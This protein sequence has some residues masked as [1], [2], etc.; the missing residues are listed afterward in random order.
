MKRNKTNIHL[1]IVFLIFLTLSS[2]ITRKEVTY[3]QGE[4]KDNYEYNF[5][6]YKLRPNDR[7]YIRLFS[8]NEEINKLLN[9]G[10][11]ANIGGAGQSQNMFVFIISDYGYVDIPQLDSVYVMNKT[12]AE[13]KI[14]VQRVLNSLYK[15]SKADVRLADFTYTILG[16]VNN[17]GMITFNENRISIIEAVAAAGDFSTF[18]DRTKVKIVRQTPEGSKIYEVDIT[19]SD[20]LSSDF[21]YLHP[22]DFVYVEPLNVAF[23]NSKYYPLLSFTSVILSTTSAVLVF[24]SLINRNNGQ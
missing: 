4:Q 8:Q 19:Q 16:E 11:Q 9:F 14:E 15:N 23:V 22:N 10:G 20:I 18:A 7:L 17:P 24:I 2:C 13:A 1:Y 12:I 6:Q 3:L 21:Y 5:T